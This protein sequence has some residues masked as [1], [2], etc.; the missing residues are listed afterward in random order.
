MKRKL[1][2]DE[3]KMCERAISQLKNRNSLIRPKIKYFDYQITDG[4]KGTM[5]EKYQEMLQKKKEIHQEL[6]ENDMKITV[7]RSQVQDGVEVK[8]KNDKEICAQCG[9]EIKQDDIPKSED[10]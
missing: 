1:T 6:F 5:E 10:K 3:T 2:D 9:Q 8:K 7:L 4:L